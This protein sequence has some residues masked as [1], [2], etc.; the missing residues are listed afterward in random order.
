MK[1]KVLTYL[2]V[3][4]WKL[5]DETFKEIGIPIIPANKLLSEIKN[6]E[7]VW[8]LFRNGITCTLNQ[9]DSDNGTRQAKQYEISSFED[10][11]M[12]AAAIRPSFDS[13]PE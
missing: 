5:I 4:V 6:D 3:K 1:I 9:V 10:G 8:D 12:I 13:W 2:I 11:A 7:R